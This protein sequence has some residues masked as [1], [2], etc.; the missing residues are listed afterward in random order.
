MAEKLGY[1]SP[2]RMLA[3]MTGPELDDWRAYYALEADVAQYQTAEGG[4]L[5]YS[6]AVQAA[7]GPKD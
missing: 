1:A 4:G 5:S 6:L 3:E 2:S 7:W